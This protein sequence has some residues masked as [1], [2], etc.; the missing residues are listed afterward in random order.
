MR[1]Q[2][3]RLAAWAVTL[4]F[5]SGL[6]LPF[7]G[8]PGQV[9]AD[10]VCG[11]VLV[12]EHTVRHFDNPTTPTGPNHCAV[13]HLRHAMAGAS[14]MAFARIERPVEAGRLLVNSTIPGATQAP[15]DHAS[16]RGPPVLV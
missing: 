16:P 1:S 5:V 12:L 9:D 13:C 15:I 3:R 11:P 14:V 8:A 10:G 7:A 2:L 4:S 6:W